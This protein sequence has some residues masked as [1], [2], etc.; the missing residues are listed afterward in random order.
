MLAFP[1]GY[2]RRLLPLVLGG[3]EFDN[4]L[5]FSYIVFLLILFS[6]SFHSSTP[7]LFPSPSVLMG[8]LGFGV[9]WSLLVLGLLRE[10]FLGFWAGGLVVLGILSG[11]WVVNLGVGWVVVL[12]LLGSCVVMVVLWVTLGVGRVC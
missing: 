1:L 7:S 8:G 10:V 5:T 2:S 3:L 9:G 6:I 4:L 11:F 12:I